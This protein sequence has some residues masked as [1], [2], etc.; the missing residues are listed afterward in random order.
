MFRGYGSLLHQNLP[1]VFGFFQDPGVHDLNQ[2][3]SANE[4][5]LQSQDAEK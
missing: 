2:I 3:V 1:N 4:I 5:H